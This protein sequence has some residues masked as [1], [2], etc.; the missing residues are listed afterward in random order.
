MVPMSTNAKF[1]SS[2]TPPANE[3]VAFGELDGT[4]FAALE[5]DE[6]ELETTLEE[7]LDVKVVLDVEVWV[8]VGV[9]VVLVVVVLVVV[10]AVPKYHEPVRTPTD[11]DAK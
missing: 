2:R 11:S 1:N 9:Y 5:V 4:T 6:K 3:I 8:V 7:E 10:G